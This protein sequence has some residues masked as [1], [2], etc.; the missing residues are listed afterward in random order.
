MV[1]VDS[2]SSHSAFSTNDPTATQT[3][4]K[5]FHPRR[6]GKSSDLDRLFQHLAESS[7]QL[8]PERVFKS[9]RTALYHASGYR[10]ELAWRIFQQMIEHKVTDL[11][12]ANHYG[13]L[14]NIIKYGTDQASVTRMLTVL[15]HM[16]EDQKTLMH[17][18]QVLF[19]MSRVGD[20]SGACT[21]INE[22][23]HQGHIPPSSHYTSLAIAARND[24]GHGATQEAA[25]LMM[26]AMKKGD[27]VLETDACVTM[28]SLLSR[29][30]TQQQM[31]ATVEDDGIDRTVK[32]LEA[33]EYA[34]NSKKE[35]D[36]TPAVTK[37]RYN[38]H[39]YTSLISGLANKGDAINAKRLYDE[40]RQQ[41]LKPTVATRTALIEAYGRAGDFDAA[42]KL[43]NRK[44]RHNNAM[45]TSVLTN[46]IRH[47]KWDVAEMLAAS[48]IERLE[49]AK[50]DDKL[51][52]ALLWV[53]VKCD[54]DDARTFFDTLYHKD[55]SFVNSVMVNH[56]V[57]ESGNRRSKQKV[58]ES[59]NLHQSTRTPPSLRS[60]HLL[61][62]ALF[63]CRDVPAALTAFMNMRRQGVPDDITMAMVV[64]GLVMNDEDTVA[65]NVFRALRSDNLQ[66]NLRAYTSMLKAFAKKQS[67]EGVVSKEILSMWPELHAVL[68]GK[69]PATAIV[70]T[71][72]LMTPLIKDPSQAYLL[73]REMTGYQTPNEYTY[74]TLIACFSKHSLARATEVF[75]HMCASGVVP[76][77]QTYTAMLQAC[78]IFRSARSALLVF[79]HMRDQQVTPNTATWH[80]LLK[81]L[82]RARVDPAK[83]D[84][85]GH[86]ARESMANK[87]S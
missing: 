37:S 78:S 2:P 16:R 7:Q 58:E 70:H 11:M 68:S 40:M 85:I 25:E 28:I 1:D 10:P 23:K 57:T 60:Q 41:G 43:L 17:Y 33:V 56:L 46:A 73:F 36:D 77:I 39:M 12:G 81:A 80:Y 74:T 18:S 48:W 79:R 47:S 29:R 53:K 19:A 65:W 64:R 26:D 6:I 51:R 82:V 69:D 45:V 3:S 20:A 42:L 21:L 15:D 32:F 71:P 22:I 49:S 86:M 24:K 83:V 50:T 30:R 14:L 87:K 13:H 76:T 59:Y 72:P 5:R 61:V 35:E 66:R 8:G 84:E 4:Y 63:K 54:L 34:R 62:D 55:S 52:A 31:T 44:H 75:S 27:V 67:S 38:V 9:L